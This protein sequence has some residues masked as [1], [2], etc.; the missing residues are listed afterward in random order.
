MVHAALFLLTLEAANAD[1][2]FTISLK[3][4]TRNLQL[5]TNSPADYPV[6]RQSIADDSRLL[7]NVCKVHERAYAPWVRILNER[8]NSIGIPALDGSHW[9]G[10]PVPSVGHLVAKGR[11]ACCV[12]STYWAVLGQ[13]K[14]Q[15]T[16]SQPAYLQLWRPQ[17]HR[18]TLTLTFFTPTSTP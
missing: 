11:S 9:Y 17:S 2:V 4:S 16:G 1:L 14:A 7:G 13:G 3:R 10:P 18:R 12:P 15:L 6:F 5:S 8:A